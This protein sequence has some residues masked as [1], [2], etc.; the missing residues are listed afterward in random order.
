MIIDFHTHIFPDALRN[1]RAKYFEGEP[2]FKGIYGDPTARMAGQEDLIAVMDEDGVDLSVA[3]GFPWSN[4]EIA[5]AHNDYIIEAQARHQTRI[6]GFGSF[7]IMAPWALKEAERCLNS[8]LHGL[9]ELAVYGRG[10]DD[11]ALAVLAD[12]GRICNNKNVPLL[13]HVNEPIGHK[14]PGKAPLNLK[15]ILSLVEVLSG[16]KVVLAHWGGG[17]FFYNLLKKEVPQALA[18]VYFDTAASPFLYQPH[19]YDIAQQITGPEKILFGSDYPLIKPS[20]YFKEMGQANLSDNVVRYIK[21]ESA[22]ALLS[23]LPVS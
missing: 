5:M 20:R 22:K 16:V 13:I 8:G 17:L 18:N 3:F 21:G 14:Y 9:G 10:F 2:S 11:K 7:D 15:M 4:H 1:D 23:K 6:A 19:I 12:L